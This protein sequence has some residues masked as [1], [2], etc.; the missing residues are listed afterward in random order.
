MESGFA[1]S[2]QV[3]ADCAERRHRFRDY[4]ISASESAQVG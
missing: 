3:C 1:E 4:P 2:N